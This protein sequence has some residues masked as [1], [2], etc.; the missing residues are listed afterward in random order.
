[1][2]LM[3]GP[4]DVLGVEAERVLP[5]GAAARRCEAE[6][7]RGGLDHL[8]THLHFV[9]LACECGGG[10]GGAECV[11]SPHG[12]LAEIRVVEQEVTLGGR[13]A[14]QHRKPS[15]QEKWVK[16]AVQGGRGWT[17]PP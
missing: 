2:G 6:Q 5:T 8:G 3:A 1:M 10:Q 9:V 17:R 12:T 15:F 16:P 13:E 14:D 7:E 11:A 4:E